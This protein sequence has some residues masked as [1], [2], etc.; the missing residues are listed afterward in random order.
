LTE[1]AD[2]AHKQQL[3]SRSS[4]V[5]SRRL[6]AVPDANDQRRGLMIE[7]P[8]GPA[9]PTHWSF[10]QIAS[11][12]GAPASYLREVPAPIVADCINYGLRFSRDIDDVGLLLTQKDD[13]TI[14]LRAATGPRY[15]RVWNCEVADALVERF[16]D[17][18]HG[19][20]RVP[21]E[22]G[23]DVVVTKDNTTLFASDRDMFVFLADEHNRIEVPGR[24]DGQAGQM[25]RGFFVWN[26]EVGAT[27]LG[28]GFFLFDFVCC[29]R[30]VWGA[31]D[32]N[33]VRIRHTAGAPDRWLEEVA[34]VLT[35]YA[36]GSARPVLETIA[37]AKQKRLD[38]V[39][40]FLAERFGKRM[41]SDVKEIH[42]LEELR[43]IETL[44]DVTTAVT[45]YARNM[46]N[47]DRR[48]ELE[49]KAG[50]VLQLAA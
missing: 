26:S 25:A 8:N 21:G 34:P 42:M 10:G 20:W 18:I 13:D 4:V 22:F 12:V 15:G 27:T 23:T 37:N 7:G 33:E 48:I 19:N 6:E 38:D 36:A 40:N 29:N 5:S 46:P 44:W 2:F 11:L 16:G 28:A 39:D 45:A 50:E 41:A 1:L 49:R 35:E 14:E 30:I 32:Y 31:R 24:R 43:P 3:R 17:G 47:S 9:E